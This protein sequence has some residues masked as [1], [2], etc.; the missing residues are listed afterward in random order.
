MQASDRYNSLFDYY[1]QMVSI[2]PAFL[3]AVAIAESALNP[4]A[5]SH[6]GAQGL[7]QFMPATWGE[8]RPHA[9]AS[10]FCSEDAIHGAA[11]M[12][13]WLFNTDLTSGDMTRV[14]AGYNWGYG[15]LRRAI[16]EHGD[17]W[18]AHAPRE[19]KNY[20]QRVLGLYSALSTEDEDNA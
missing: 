1:G 19:T 15:N 18:L 11:H 12:L 13:N 17:D 14:L 6:A 16:N 7:M 9:E 2:D 8:W 3:K 4:Q 5:T 10:P 20:I